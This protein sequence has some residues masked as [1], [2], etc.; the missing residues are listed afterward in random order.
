METV[1][2][3]FL[4]QKMTS[5]ILLVIL[6]QSYTYAFFTNSGRI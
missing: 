5:K 4:I 2:G 6:L 3:G 1:G